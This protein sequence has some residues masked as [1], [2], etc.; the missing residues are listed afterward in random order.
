MNTVCQK[1]GSRNVANVNN[2]RLEVCTCYGSD[3]KKIAEEIAFA[4][5][6]INKLKACNKQEAMKIITEL[7]K[8]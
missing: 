2:G 6:T 1:V 4:M 5:N 3:S 7:K 8:Q